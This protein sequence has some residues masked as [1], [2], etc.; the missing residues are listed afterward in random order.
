MSFPVY[1]WTGN[2]TYCITAYNVQKWVNILGRVETLNLMYLN[3]VNIYR[4]ILYVLNAFKLK[5]I[6]TYMCVQYG[7]TIAI[8]IVKN[9]KITFLHTCLLSN[10]G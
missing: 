9:M 1:I 8:T 5:I 10:F 4:W 7:M 6:N 2:D 3:K